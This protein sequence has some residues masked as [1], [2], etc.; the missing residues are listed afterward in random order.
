MTVYLAN[1][2]FD[3][4]PCKLTS[5]E[6]LRSFEKYPTP[7]SSSQDNHH[8]HEFTLAAKKVREYV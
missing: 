5:T 6:N 4:M 8:H 3:E 2:K 7:S 1:N